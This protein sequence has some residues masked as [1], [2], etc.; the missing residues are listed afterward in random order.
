[1]QGA[2]PGSGPQRLRL[3]SPGVRVADARA[4]D[5]V[6]IRR[7]CKTFSRLLRR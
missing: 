1:M 6:K 5:G 3:L 2:A 4:S 7:P